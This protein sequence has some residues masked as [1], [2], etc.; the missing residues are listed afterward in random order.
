M[1][2]QTEGGTLIT[3]DDIPAYRMCVLKQRMKLELLGLKF[4]IRTF[5]QVKKEFG[6]KGTNQRVYEQ[7]V[8]KFFSQPAT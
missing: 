7:F 6:L 1:I 4:G 2:S 8:E 5:P 3:G